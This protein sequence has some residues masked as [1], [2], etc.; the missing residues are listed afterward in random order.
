MEVT[1]K[2]HRGSRRYQSFFLQLQ[3]KNKK[4]NLPLPTIKTAFASSRL[5]T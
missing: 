5:V 1:F 2:F 3:L 4:Q